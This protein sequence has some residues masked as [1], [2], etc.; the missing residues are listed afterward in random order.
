MDS[1]GLNGIINHSVESNLE[2]RIP[3]ARQ[4]SLQEYNNNDKALFKSLSFLI[5]NNQSID[6]AMNYLTEDMDRKGKSKFKKKL[7]AIYESE[8][9]GEIAEIKSRNIN[10]FFDTLGWK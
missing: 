3:Q 7:I 10:S 4:K 9:K 2:N 8:I 1:K 5:Q 6:S